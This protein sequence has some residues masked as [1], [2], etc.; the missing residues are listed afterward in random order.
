[1]EPGALLGDLDVASVKHNLATPLG[2]ASLV[3]IGGQALDLGMGFL[4]PMFGFLIN[5]IIE[6]GKIAIFSSFLHLACYTVDYED[7][8]YETSHNL[9]IHYF[10]NGII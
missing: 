2:T 9:K 10:K 3:G 6:Y 8:T 1:M 4:T 7:V 5:N